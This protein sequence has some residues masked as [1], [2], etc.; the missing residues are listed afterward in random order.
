MSC[1]ANAS[2]RAELTGVTSKDMETVFEPVV[3]IIIE[4]VSKQVEKAESSGKT[5]VTVCVHQNRTQPL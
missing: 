5:P 1:L 3:G 4:M 2:E